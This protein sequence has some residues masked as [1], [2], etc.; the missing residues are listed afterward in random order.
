[1]NAVVNAQE[2]RE[3]DENTIR[4]LGMPQAVLMERAALETFR[5]MKDR[6]RDRLSHKRI[7][8]FA[9][10]GNNGGDGVALARL[11]L[12]DGCHVQ[13]FLS[14]Q[15]DHY[16]EA[17]KAQL[18]IWEKLGG[19]VHALGFTDLFEAVSRDCILV[20][21]LFGTGL[22]RPIEGIYAQLIEQ[23]NASDA[24]R[25]SMDIPSGIS[26]D[27]GSVMGVAVQADLT[28]TYG[29]RKRGLMLYPG[30]SY[31]GDLQVA[32]IGIPLAARSILPLG[33]AY[34]D[35]MMD[36]L[37]RHADSHKGTYGKVLLIAGSK[38]MPGASILAGSAVLQSG[39]GMLKVLAPD[40][41]RALLA[42]ALPEA[43]PICYADAQEAE[44]RLKAHADW[45]DVIAMGPGIGKS[46]LTAGILEWVL[47]HTKQPLILDADALGILADDAGLYQTVLD[48]AAAGR[49]IAVTP[50]VGE[51]ARLMHAPLQA[52][53]MQ[54]MQMAEQWCRSHDL[55]L[56]SK[57]AATVLMHR[58]KEGVHCFF[59]D[60]GNSGMATAGSGDVLT[61][62]LAGTLAQ[63]LQHTDWT[64]DDSIIRM[65]GRNDRVAA[66]LA[67]G[68]HLHG[69][70]G[71]LAAG[72]LGEHGLTASSIGQMLPDLL[73]STERR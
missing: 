23:M 12:L 9:G 17:L 39:A 43:M 72:K 41:N 16:S 46:I 30:R 37:I 7:Y 40:C 56:I 11:L 3:L 69:M 32:E 70:A 5:C 52:L 8:V 34:S 6:F 4:N 62:I 2:M 64:G 65:T 20:D 27:D 28:V 50:H 44:S 19:S 73:N 18:S 68:I 14:G 57:D 54:R 26:S 10:N 29:Y 47:N 31:A 59:N 66:A 53:T 58:R 35:E 61:G 25:I 51:L 63:V 1:M 71:D 38:D 24:F 67:L 55:Y 36:L 22:S 33:F 45:A 42:S 21:A 48:E 13:L 15:A 49:I 60:T